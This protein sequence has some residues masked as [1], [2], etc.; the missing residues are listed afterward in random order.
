MSLLHQVLPIQ[1]GK[2]HVL[3]SF[4]YDGQ[5]AR[6]RRAEMANPAILDTTYPDAFDPAT[7]AQY[8]AIYAPEPRFSPKYV[9]GGGRA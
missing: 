6:L 2:R 9:S 8:G 1:S 3:L 4:L 7:M 5:G